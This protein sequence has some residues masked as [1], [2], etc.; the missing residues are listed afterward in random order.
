MIELHTS[1]RGEM[2]VVRTIAF[3]LRYYAESPRRET[4]LGKEFH[5]RT[6]H[7]ITA[8]HTGRG[9][10]AGIPIGFT[11]VN[12]EMHFVARWCVLYGIPVR[13]RLL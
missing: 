4:P 10:R 8:C 6:A 7:F 11:D 5:R 9:T 13:A 1:W 12:Y 2:N 3:F